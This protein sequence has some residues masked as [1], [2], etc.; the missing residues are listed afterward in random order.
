[1]STAAREF[2]PEAPLIGGRA[3]ERCRAVAILPARNEQD[4]LAASLDAFACQR[5]LRGEL[6]DRTTFEVIL[7]LNNCTDASAS[8]ARAWKLAHPAVALHIV[9]RSIPPDRAHVGTARRMLMDTAWARLDGRAGSAG[10]LS[11]DSDTVVAPHWIAQNLRALDEGADAVGGVIGLKAGELERLPKGARTAYL[12]DRE[13]QRLF[14][15]LEDLLDPL[16]GDPCPRHLEHFGA[17]LA[18]TPAVYKRA[19]GLPAVNP[20]EDMAFVDALFRID[21]RLRHDPAVQVFTSARLEGRAAVGL[22]WQLRTWQKESEAGNPH[23]VPSCAWLEHRFRSLR[24]LRELHHAGRQADLGFFDRTWRPRVRRAIAEDLTT[25][26]FLARIDCDR[27]IDETF[28]ASAREAEIRSVNR[29]LRAAAARLRESAA[30]ERTNEASAEETFRDA[31]VIPRR[32]AA[33]PS[34]TAPLGV[35]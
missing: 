26:E 2:S 7:L 17:S 1:L 14:A 15:E 20:L 25:G 9:E 28:A 3:H 19:G 29:R 27:W 11:T 33:G 16:A 5:D 34:G 30:S 4:S 35:R 6:L 22:S 13:Y 23:L 8:A 31:A 32:A 24:L 18:C 10:I 12:L 21:A